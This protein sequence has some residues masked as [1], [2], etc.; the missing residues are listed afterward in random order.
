MRANAEG[1]T[2]YIPEGRKID[3]SGFGELQ[4]YALKLANRRDRAGNAPYTERMIAH[5]LMKD[6]NL[7]RCQAKI[8]GG[9]AY[10]LARRVAVQ[11]IERTKTHPVEDWRSEV[12]ARIA[13]C[14]ELANDTPWPGR[15]GPTDRRVLEGAYLTATVRPVRSLPPLGTDVGAPSRDC[16]EHRLEGSCSARASAIH[17]QDH[18]RAGTAAGGRVQAAVSRS[19]I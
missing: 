14:R 18:A 7:L 6:D 13:R 11:A 2:R 16:R 1:R 3:Q 5:A 10:D 9:K 8:G 19:A 17:P 15:T 4:S 12:P